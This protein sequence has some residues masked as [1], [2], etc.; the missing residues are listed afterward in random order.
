MSVTPKP[1]YGCGK[2][3]QQTRRNILKQKTVDS[4]KAMAKTSG[5]TGQY[6]IVENDK[7]S[8]FIAITEDTYS[9]QSIAVRL[10]FDSG[11]PVF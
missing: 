7:G 5:Y 4:A 1:C 11:T 9:G 2:S 10:L 8:D 6:L 3:I